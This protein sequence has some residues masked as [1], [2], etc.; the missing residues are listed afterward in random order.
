MVTKHVEKLKPWKLNKKKFWWKPLFRARAHNNL[1][2]SALFSVRDV[3]HNNGQVCFYQPL[4]V[5]GTLASDKLALTF[6]PLPTIIA[7]GYEARG[8]IEAVKIK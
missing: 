8:K 2:G 3:R 6:E 5:S 1:F 4:K 7:D